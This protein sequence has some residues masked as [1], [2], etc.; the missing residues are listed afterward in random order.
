MVGVRGMES[1]C[2]G[3]GAFFFHTSWLPTAENTHWKLF[4]CCTL[5][6]HTGGTVTGLTGVQESL[7]SPSHSTHTDA[8]DVAKVVRAVVNKQLLAVI[9]GRKHSSYPRI[10]T[11]PLKNWD[12]DKTREWIEGKKVEFRKFRGILL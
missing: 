6:Y 9:R 2:I 3:A 1:V 12:L 8:Q 7:L 5:C 4:D 10:A 11:N